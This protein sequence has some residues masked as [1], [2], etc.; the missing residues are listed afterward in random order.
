MSEINQSTKSVV[1]TDNHPFTSEVKEILSRMDVKKSKLVLKDYPDYNIK[2]YSLIGIIKEA[3]GIELLKEICMP[4][5][6][7]QK[8]IQPLDV[9][10]MLTDTE[11]DSYI[12]DCYVMSVQ[13][14]NDHKG[15]YF[16]TGRQYSENDP[17]PYYTFKTEEF[18]YEV[19]KGVLYK[20]DYR[21]E[22][23]Q[24]DHFWE[25]RIT[26]NSPDS[27]TFTLYIDQGL[28]GNSR[29][30]MEVQL[31]LFLNKLIRDTSKIKEYTEY[32]CRKFTSN[33]TNSY[34]GYA[35]VDEIE[36]K[37]PTSVEKLE[38]IH[39]VLNSDRSL[40]GINSFSILTGSLKFLLSSVKKGDIDTYLY[41]YKDKIT[42]IFW[43]MVGPLVGLN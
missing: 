5:Q 29:Y 38:K 28:E 34:K 9:M 16:T 17:S 33:A 22:G 31:P 8:V 13:Y 27:E 23:N 14:V 19:Y 7:T 2:K 18:S 42:D 25:V 24:F 37:R 4:V 35:Y 20:Y 36:G 21:R 41:K 43:R 30:I 32:V 12:P 10:G 26:Y 6:R 3:E 11:S 39:N 15:I 1:S 40:S